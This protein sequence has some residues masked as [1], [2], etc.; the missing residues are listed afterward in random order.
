MLNNLSVIQKLSWS[1]KFYKMSYS[2]FTVT[3]FS[4]SQF[5]M[6]LFLEP[7]YLRIYF[8]VLKHSY[9]CVVVKSSRGRKFPGPTPFNFQIRIGN[10]MASVNDTANGFCGQTPNVPPVP[11]PCGQNDKAVECSSALVGRY[12]VIKRSNPITNPES[13]WEIAE[14][15]AFA[16]GNFGDLKFLN[17]I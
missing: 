14:I 7:F 4:V 10:T 2:F 5:Y 1:K 13:N 15:Y 12:L 6:L 8:F 9:T 11:Y 16:Y 17:I 3:I